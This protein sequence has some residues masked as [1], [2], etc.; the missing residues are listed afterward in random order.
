MKRRLERLQSRLRKEEL[1]KRGKDV[2]K[3]STNAAPT[4]TDDEIDDLE[5]APDAEVEEL[6]A[7]V[8]DLATAAQS[9]EELRAEIEILNKLTEL[10]EEVRR[11]GIMPAILLPE[12]P[13][14]VFL[15]IRH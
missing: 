1:I 12:L 15:F 2:A 14:T 5:D 4:L 10:A 9:I 7:Q 6:E 13:S 8:I 3:T 11:Y